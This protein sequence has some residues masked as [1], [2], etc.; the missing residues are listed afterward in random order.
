MSEVKAPEAQDLNIGTQISHVPGNNST[1]DLQLDRD[2]DFSYHS[3][4]KHRYDPQ[5]D[6]DH[7]FSY[8]SYQ[9]H[10]RPTAGMRP[11]FSYHSDQEHR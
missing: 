2:H 4:Q 1:S 7:D 5:L 6:R 10:R 3:S 11:G 9:E 8:Q